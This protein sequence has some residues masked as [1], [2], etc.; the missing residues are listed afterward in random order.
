M[1]SITVT[2]IFSL[3]DV[4]DQAC[5]RRNGELFCFLPSAQNGA[6][7]VIL[8]LADSKAY[9]VLRNTPILLYTCGC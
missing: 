3:Q 5:I 1:G 2:R 9:A 8:A 7:V 6:A 4:E